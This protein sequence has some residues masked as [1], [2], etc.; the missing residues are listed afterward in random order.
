MRIMPMPSLF[1]PFPAQQKVAQKS[2]ELAVAITAQVRDAVSP[3]AKEMD[4]AEARGYIRGKATPII[5]HQLSVYRPQLCELDDDALQALAADV[6]DRVVR[7]VLDDVVRSKVLSTR[8]V[9]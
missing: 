5:A 7:L 2:V 6:A 9:A 4:R 3:K 8:K 1:R